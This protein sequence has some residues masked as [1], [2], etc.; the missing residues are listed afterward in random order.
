MKRDRS[1][2]ASLVGLLYVILMGLFAFGEPGEHD[3][4]VI[5][6]LSVWAIGIMIAIRA[7]VL[8]IECLVHAV[9]SRDERKRM[10]WVIS[11]AVFGVPAAYA[12]YFIKRRR[13][14]PVP[15][16]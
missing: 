4:S 7:F 11:L 13:T 12:Y 10:E 3:D 15:R 6:S 2:I 8:W 9:K 16:E 14:Q 5:V 1:V